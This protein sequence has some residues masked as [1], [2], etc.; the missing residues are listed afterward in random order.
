MSLIDAA[1]DLLFD[2][3]CPGCQLPGKGLCSQCLTMIMAQTVFKPY[4]SGI[5]VP[6]WSGGYYIEPLTSVIAQAKEH[7]RWD[8]I[9][10][11]SR[12]LG[13]AVAGLADELGLLGHGFLVPFPSQTTAIQARGYDITWALAKGA[14]QMLSR[15]GL[16]AHPT[17][18]LHHIRLIEDQA[19]LTSQERF[20]NLEGC[21]K[22]T[23]RPGV[24]W[25]VLIDD[26]A[27]TGSSL[28][29]GVRALHCGGY[30]VDGLATVAATKL[31]SKGGLGAQFA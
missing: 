11:L 1:V 31:H 25:L 21:L 30:N 6:L 20:I 23:G 28:R 26:V 8:V 18:R 15:V 19:G 14:A 16:Y 24:G 5:D 10:V 17:R 9:E 3:T 7:Q 12:R 22:A 13:L 2:G 29:E 4:R 27:T